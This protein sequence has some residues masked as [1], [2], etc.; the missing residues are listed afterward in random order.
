MTSVPGDLN[1]DA[2]LSRP[3]PRYGFT[4]FKIPFLGDQNSHHAVTL[5]NIIAKW[6]I[7]LRPS[8]LP[9]RRAL[10]KETSAATMQSLSPS[11]T[12]DLSA[13]LRPS[14]GYNF[15]NS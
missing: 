11:C 3:Y 6:P 9:T 1:S 13:I 7:I 15:T 10:S 5:P 4:V 14:T 2:W 12:I 8:H